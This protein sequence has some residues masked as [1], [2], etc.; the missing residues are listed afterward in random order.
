MSGG[1]GCEPAGDVVCRVQL[2][3]AVSEGGRG[4]LSRRGGSE[5]ATLGVTALADVVAMQGRVSTRRQTLTAGVFQAFRGSARG[6]SAAAID[7][8]SRGT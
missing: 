6:T 5:S 4:E 8:C 3:Y 2:P 1:D 7:E